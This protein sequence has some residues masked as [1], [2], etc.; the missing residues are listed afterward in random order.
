MVSTQT[1]LVNLEAT[2]VERIP[3]T[4]VELE[5]YIGENLVLGDH[6]EPLQATDVIFVDVFVEGSG[7]RN[8]GSHAGDPF[9]NATFNL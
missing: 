2:A 7:E 6:V 1:W 5:N 8:I 9:V 4:V 3:A